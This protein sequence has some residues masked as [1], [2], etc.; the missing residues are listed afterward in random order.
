MAPVCSLSKAE[1]HK[2][3]SVGGSLIG[4]KVTE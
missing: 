4:V 3:A 2:R 1:K